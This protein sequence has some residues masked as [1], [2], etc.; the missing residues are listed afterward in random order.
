VL[1][2]GVVALRRRVADLGCCSVRILD[3]LRGICENTKKGRANVEKAVKESQRLDSSTKK[4]L[5]GR[6][7]ADDWKSLGKWSCVCGR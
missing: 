5:L 6:I 4:S 3:I 1:T 7:Q 2:V